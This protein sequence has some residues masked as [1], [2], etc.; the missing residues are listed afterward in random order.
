MDITNPTPETDLTE[1]ILK[2]TEGDS[3]AEKLVISFAYQRFKDLARRIKYRTSKASTDELKLVAAN[4]T[5]LVHEA[6]I[7]LK[8]S[9]LPAFE[10]R[11]KFFDFF[12]NVLYSV[13][14]DEVR[15]SRASKRNQV[16]NSNIANTQLSEYQIDKLIDIEASLKELESSH[17]RKVT[18][19]LQKYICDSSIKEIAEIQSVSESTV[20]K[21]IKFVK[22]V[23]K[24]RAKKNNKK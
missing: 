9:H 10:S 21:D 20:D 23:I 15:K 7:K 17:K 11:N 18:S 16:I 22:S 19:F 4:T 6:F 14:M 1:I 5:S 8:S 12:S 3:L 2:F 13:F 24:S